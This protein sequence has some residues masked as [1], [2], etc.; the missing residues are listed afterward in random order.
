MKA[1]EK[2]EMKLTFQKQTAHIGQRGNNF[3]VKKKKVTWKCFF[4]EYSSLY[5]QAIF[6]GLENHKVKYEQV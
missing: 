4:K 3:Q 6:L 1:R 5:L 2:G